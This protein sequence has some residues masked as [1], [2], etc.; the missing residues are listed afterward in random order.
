M[1]QVLIIIISIPFLFNISGNKVFSQSAPDSISS[2]EISSILSEFKD[3]S[4]LHIGFYGTTQNCL[5]FMVY[6]FKY[7]R[8]WFLIADQNKNITFLVVNPPRSE[9]KIVAKGSNFLLLGLGKTYTN[10]Y[11]KLKKRRKIVKDIEIYGFYKF[12]KPGK[13]AVKGLLL[14]EFPELESEPSW[15]FKWMSGKAAEAIES[16]ESVMPEINTEIAPPPV[17]FK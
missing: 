5:P 10:N 11:L 14:L 9:S 3:F 4:E 17:P 2:N 16:V 7:K 15:P 8:T 6:G 13:K 1:K 12:N